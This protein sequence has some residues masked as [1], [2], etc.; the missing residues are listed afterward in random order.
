[1]DADARSAPAAPSAARTS[2]TVVLLPTY[3]EA[4]NL[5]RML[6][7]IRAHLPDADVL[8]VDDGSPDGTGALADAAAT[9]DFHVKVAHRP[10]KQ[11]LGVA[12]RFAY[13]WSL[14]MGYE[15]V[16]QMDCDF[17]HDPRDLPR[18]AHL[19]GRSPV[20]VGS[21]RCAGGGCE[22]WPW[23]RDALSRAG[24]LYARRVLE[25]PVRDLTSGF[26]GFQR[27]ALEALPLEELRTDGYGFQIEVTSH[28]VAR[29]FAV[30]EMPI[31]FT[32]RKWGQSK[33]SGVIVA[34]AM[35]RVWTIRAATRQ[36]RV[37]G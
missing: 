24:S 36:V 7:A 22:G 23:Y 31:T 16:I 17:S 18:M 15:R 6:R 9:E 28:L 27:Q 10:G 11:G 8:V 13:R 1:M 26:K 4:G 25:S 34:E 12:Y 37:D 32:D 3:N 30:H 5:P 21:R 35:L 19:L 14:E 20:V 2:D 33:M 29:G